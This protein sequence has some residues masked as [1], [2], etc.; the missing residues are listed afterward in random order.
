MKDKVTDRG[1]VGVQERKRATVDLEEPGA[2]AGR[3][4]VD[5]SRWSRKQVSVIRD[6]NASGALKYCALA[7]PQRS[8]T[9]QIL[10][11]TTQ[12]WFFEQFRWLEMHVRLGLHPSVSPERRSSVSAPRISPPR[13]LN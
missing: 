13:L 10:R 2:A 12:T 11:K 4:P 8:D 5:R 1:Q 9:C 7:G 6:G 3:L